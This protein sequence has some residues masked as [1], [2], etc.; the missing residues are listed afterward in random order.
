V[1]TNSGF[2]RGF[3]AMVAVVAALTTFVGPVQA[4]NGSITVDNE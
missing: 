3:A 1:D 4:A 2:R